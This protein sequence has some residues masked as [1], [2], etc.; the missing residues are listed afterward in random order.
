MRS[1]EFL[2][3][4]E[5]INSLDLTEYMTMGGASAVTG[6]AMEEGYAA[7][8]RLKNKKG[9]NKRSKKEREKDKKILLA[10]LLAGTAGAGA[11]VRN[12]NRI[13]KK[14]KDK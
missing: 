11:T 8:E 13:I 7:Y 12:A 3:Y 14:I 2:L 1:N 9:K 10:S 6:I 5:A 4:K